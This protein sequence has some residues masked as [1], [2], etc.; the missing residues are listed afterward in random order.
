MT[1]PPPRAQPPLGLIA[2]AAL[3]V[4][5]VG[6]AAVGA[7][8]GDA[9]DPSPMTAAT[10]VATAT[11][12][13]V[14]GGSAWPAETPTPVPTPTPAP[15]TP[16]PTPSL[17]DITASLEVCRDQRDGRC[18]DRLQRVDDDGFVVILSFEGAIPGD[19]FAFRLDGPDGRSVNGGSI[20]V[21]GS[22]GR[23]WSTFRGDLPRG[24]WAAVVTRGEEEIART[25]FAAR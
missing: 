3:L 6:G 16:T 2:I 13:V 8:T 12:V 22:A 23:A 25:E 4:L 14:A 5:A 7:L 1:G 20:T 11:P 19:T 21:N 17:G 9:P 18:T 24:D 10:T 15:P